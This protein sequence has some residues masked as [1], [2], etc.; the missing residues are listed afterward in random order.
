MAANGRN[1]TV[2]LGHWASAHAAFMRL[3]G[4]LGSDKAHFQAALMQA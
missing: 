1:H 3:C 2:L 4:D